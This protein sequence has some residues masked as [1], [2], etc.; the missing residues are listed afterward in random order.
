MNETE[1]VFCVENGS[2]LKKSLLFW[3]GV[4]EKRGGDVEGEGARGCL[5]AISRVKKVHHH[6]CVFVGNLGGRI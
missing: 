3:V 6:A 1:S 5:H 2:G 4:L